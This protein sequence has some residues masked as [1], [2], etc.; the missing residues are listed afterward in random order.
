VTWW[1]NE[2]FDELEEL[3][4]EVIYDGLEHMVRCLSYGL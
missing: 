3:D 2:Y 4:R 1:L